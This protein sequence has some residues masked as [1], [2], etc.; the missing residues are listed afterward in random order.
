MAKIKIKW[1]N[2]IISD[3]LVNVLKT[4]NKKNSHSEYLLFYYFI[5]AFLSYTGYPKLLALVVYNIRPISNL[6]VLNDV[7]LYDS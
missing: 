3:R 1:D 6:K 7:H 4:T 2:I 5:I